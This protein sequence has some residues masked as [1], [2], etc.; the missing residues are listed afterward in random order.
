MSYIYCEYAT[1]FIH[2]DE[3]VGFECISAINDDEFKAIVAQ[4]PVVGILRNAVLNSRIYRSP[5]RHVDISFHQILIVGY[6]FDE[7]G[8]PYWIIQRSYGKGWENQGFGYV[9]RRIRS[10]LEDD[11]SYFC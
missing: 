6:G 2:T 8:Q 7:F 9:Y 5:R 10:G 11:K 1:K 4:K 3:V